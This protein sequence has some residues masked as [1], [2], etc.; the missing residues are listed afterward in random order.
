MD[1][2]ANK[3]G[4]ETASRMKTERVYPSAGPCA[5]K[6][7]GPCGVVIFGASGDLTKRKILPALYRL[8]KN[9]YLSEHFFV[10]GMGRTEMSIDQFREKILS[11]LKNTFQKDFDESS[12][13]ELV[14]KIY[15]FP[16]DYTVQETYAQ[17]LKERLLQLE[18]KHGTG[19]NRP[20]LAIP[21]TLYE[22]VISNFGT[23][24]FPE[25]RGQT[26]VVIEAFGR[27]LIQPGTN[28][29]VKN[30]LMKTGLPH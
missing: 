29:I 2:D 12:W 8:Q 30:S 10:L 19:G 24:D 11:A 25:R 17:S 7:S 4:G 14:E 5:I 22:H 23:T 1:S 20:Y 18:K 27:D 6:I 13:N 21:P 16:M 15:Y 28:R 26:H 9:R 3:N